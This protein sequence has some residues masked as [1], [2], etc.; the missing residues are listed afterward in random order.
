MDVNFIGIVSTARAQA[1]VTARIEQRQRDCTISD[2]AIIIHSVI[3]P[4]CRLKTFILI[5]INKKYFKLPSLVF[6]SDG[7][8]N[9]FEN[10]TTI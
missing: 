8:F 10:K 9:K 7:S 2:I 3:S 5:N 1:S 6:G 4:I